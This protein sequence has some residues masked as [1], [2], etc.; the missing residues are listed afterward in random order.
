PGHLVAAVQLGGDR[1]RLVDVLVET[2]E[3][4]H[5]G[6][7]TAHRFEVAPS[8]ALEP[9]GVQDVLIEELP[10]RAARRTCI[11]DVRAGP[12]RRMHLVAL[13]G[14]GF[15]WLSID[16]APAES[17]PIHRLGRM[18]RILI[19]VQGAGCDREGRLFLLLARVI[20]PDD[21]PLEATHGPVQ[22]LNHI[23][24]T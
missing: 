19:Q 9:V 23:G 8:L 1:R 24:P 14:P 2:S 3:V 10:E 21:V 15:S 18:Y 7:R 4:A 5:D 16:D 13:D 20:Q 22:I 12:R 6:Y 17:T 11:R